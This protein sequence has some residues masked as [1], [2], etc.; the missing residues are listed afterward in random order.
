[1]GTAF[2]ILNNQG[3]SAIKGTFAGLPDGSTFTVKVG[4][5]VMTF[6]ISYVGGTGNDVTLKRI[7]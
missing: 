2:T 5:T 1:V 4:G 6:R 7:S 3:S